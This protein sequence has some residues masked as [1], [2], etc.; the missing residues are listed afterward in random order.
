[1][2][3][4]A[5]SGENRELESAIPR[6]IVHLS[7]GA[8]EAQALHLE[9]SENS[10]VSNRFVANANRIGQPRYIGLPFNVPLTRTEPKKA[11]PTKARCGHSPRT[12]N[13]IALDRSAIF[14][15]LE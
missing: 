10:A 1:M 6:R 8:I 13:K 4:V 2:S 12:S 9:K 14:A 7:Q 15:V 11:F 3:A 5:T